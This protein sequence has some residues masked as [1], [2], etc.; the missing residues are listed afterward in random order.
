MAICGLIQSL[1]AGNHSVEARREAV[2]LLLPMV[3]HSLLSSSQATDSAARGSDSLALLFRDSLLGYIV[4]PVGGG[5]GMLSPS[6]GLE[7][8]KENS[9]SIVGF[10][11]LTRVCHAA[12]VT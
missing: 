11:T 4:A 5:E 6:A 1:C 7:N 3:E 2:A 12:T 8:C 9:S 10:A